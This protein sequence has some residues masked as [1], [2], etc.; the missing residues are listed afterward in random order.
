MLVR[1][2]MKRLFAWRQKTA[3][4]ASLPRPCLIIMVS[5]RRMHNN[6]EQTSERS[7]DVFPL[8]NGQLW[9]G[10]R[11]KI[12]RTLAHR[13]GLLNLVVLSS[14]VGVCMCA[15]TL[16]HRTPPKERGFRPRA[17]LWGPLFSGTTH[18]YR[19]P[20]PFWVRGVWSWYICPLIARGK[21]KPELEFQAGTRY[22][23]VPRR[24]PV[25][26]LWANVCM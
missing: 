22:Q 15:S 20:K 23:L 8:S 18:L 10:V 14:L 6:E 19:R 26:T 7:D 25:G 3:S 5:V 17:R 11:E 21:F 4:V 1:P 16:V 24:H 9:T 12:P 2:A 13:V